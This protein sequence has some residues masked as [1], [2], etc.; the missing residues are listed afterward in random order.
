MSLDP[1]H[2]I[3]FPHAAFRKIREELLVQ[4]LER[5]EIEPCRHVGVEKLQE[6][7]QELVKEPFEKL[8]VS[9]S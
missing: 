6:V 4:E 1:S 8:V 2:H 9:H 3:G 5:R 7:L